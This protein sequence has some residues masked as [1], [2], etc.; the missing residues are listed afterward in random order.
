VARLEGAI[1]FATLL[2]RWQ[3]LHLADDR[4]PEYR[5]NFNLRGLTAL[6]VE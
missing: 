2:R 3:D 4:P 1:V 5:E 6:R